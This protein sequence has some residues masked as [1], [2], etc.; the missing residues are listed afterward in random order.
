MAYANMQDVY[1]NMQ[2]VVWICTYC[3][4]ITCTVHGEPEEY[5]KGIYSVSAPSSVSINF[6]DPQAHVLFSYDPQKH[7]GGAKQN[8]YLKICEI[9]TQQPAIYLKKVNME[10]DSAFLNININVSSKSNTTCHCSKKNSQWN[11]TE[12]SKICTA[13]A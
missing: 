10:R 4:N 2:D 6:Y 9:I 12:F 3:S 7:W 5:L 1:A 13:L 11:S 8:R